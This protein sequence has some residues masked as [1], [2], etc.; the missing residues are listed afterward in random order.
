MSEISGSLYI[1][2]G[3]RRSAGRREPIINPATGEHIG[4]YAHATPEEID[5]AV[6]AAGAVVTANVIADD[7]VATDESARWGRWA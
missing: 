2:G 4:E 1:D 5:D 6:V 3:Y 7:V